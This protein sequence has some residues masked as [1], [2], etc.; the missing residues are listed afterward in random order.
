M[1]GVGLRCVGTGEMVENCLIRSVDRPIRNGGVETSVDM[2]FMNRSGVAPIRSAVVSGLNLGRNPEWDVPDVSRGLLWQMGI[3]PS[4][5]EIADRNGLL[6]SNNA[7]RPSAGADGV[8]RIQLA[9]F[10]SET[11]SKE[12][13]DAAAKKLRKLLD[14]PLLPETVLPHHPSLDCLTWSRAISG[15]PG[16]V[17]NADKIAE[18]VWDVHC[19]FTLG[20]KPGWLQAVID[21]LRRY[22][23]ALCYLVARKIETDQRVQIQK[24][25]EFHRQTAMAINNTMIPLFDGDVMEEE[26]P[27]ILLE[28]RDDILIV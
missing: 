8:D 13:S 27:P 15:L 14:L 25:I 2:V 10:V 5:P 3:T 24:V 26:R 1:G 19:K 16:V 7:F 9:D 11:F 23:P 6:D 22:S 21:L 18:L 4:A 28:V 17:N 20:D 12:D